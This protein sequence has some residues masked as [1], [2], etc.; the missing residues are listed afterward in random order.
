MLTTTK[1]EYMTINHPHKKYQLGQFIKIEEH[2]F[3]NDTF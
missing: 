3:K 2:I 1:M